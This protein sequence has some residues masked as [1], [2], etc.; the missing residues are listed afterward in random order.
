[1]RTQE[2]KRIEIDPQEFVDG[3]KKCTKEEVIR[4]Y[5]ELLD[6]VVMLTN[7]NNRLQQKIQGEK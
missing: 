4:C 5:M 3:F 6:L 2:T 7:K 1:M